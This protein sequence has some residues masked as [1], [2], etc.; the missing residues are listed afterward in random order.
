MPCTAIFNFLEAERQNNEANILGGIFMAGFFVAGK[1]NGGN[2]YIADWPKN[3]N[4]LHYQ[5]SKILVG[6]INDGDKYGG[7]A[8]EPPH[9]PRHKY[10][11]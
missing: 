7:L 3:H 5:A 8:E 2:K 9:Y 1:I 11:T 6:K 10:P 4:I